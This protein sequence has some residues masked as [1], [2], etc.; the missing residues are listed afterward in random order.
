MTVTD[1]PT[2]RVEVDEAQ[3]LFE[4][5]KQRRKRRWL[6]AV[7]ATFAFVILFGIVIG[8][9]AIGGVGDSPR[10]VALPSPAPSASAAAGA[11]FSI[12]PV[13]CYAPALTVAKGQVPVTGP[14]PTCSASSQLTA[15]NLNVQQNPSNVT[16]PYNFNT[17]IP[18]D[19]QFAAQAS[20]PST[21]DNKNATVLLPAGSGN[22]GPPRYVLGPAGLTDSAVKSANAQLVNN[23]WVVNLNL[24]STGSTRWDALAQQQFHAI[25]G[26]VIK[27]RVVS[28]PI[29]QPIQSSFATFNGRLQI[30]GAFTEHQAKTIAS[31]L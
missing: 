31:E 8:S 5:A 27:G 30:S 23:Q 14:L 28:A 29:T 21:D 19:T 13:L 11:G 26:V 24:T 2:H 12:R 4:E 22:Q 7:I 25:V 6:I 20:T 18:E 17:N 9:L 10:P 3:L 1:V 16:Q 15:A